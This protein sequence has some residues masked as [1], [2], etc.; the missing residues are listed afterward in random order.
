MGTIFDEKPK[1]LTNRDSGTDAIGPKNVF[2]TETRY[3]VFILMFFSCSHTMIFYR[4][5]ENSLQINRLNADNLTHESRYNE[6]QHNEMPKWLMQNNNNKQHAVNSI[7][8]VSHCS[9]DHKW[10]IHCIE[11]YWCMRHIDI[12]RG[13]QRCTCICV[14]LSVTA[15]ETFYRRLWRV[16]IWTLIINQRIFNFMRVQL[17]K[18]LSL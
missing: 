18:T 16:S 15:C 13:M 9:D 8:G 4:N 10:T 7:A 5:F 3:F 1:P 6:L 17:K 14:P 12:V 11:L 2:S